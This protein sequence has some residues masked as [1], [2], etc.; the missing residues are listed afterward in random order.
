MASTSVLKLSV[1]DREYNASLKQAAQGMK[2]L[3]QTL[4]ESGRSFSQA[5]KSVVEYVQGIG[6]METRSKTARGEINEMTSAFIELSKIYNKMS[7]EAKQGD[8][9]K[10]LSQ[11]L[12]QLRK[13]TQES[14]AELDNI[15]SSIN[16]SNGLS[17]ALDAIAG[18]FGLSIDQIT[19]FGSAAGVATTVVKVAKDAFFNNEEQLDEWGRTVEAA[20]S[21]YKGFLNSLNTGDI[22]GFLNNISTITQAAREAYNALD[23]LATFNAFNKA[24]IAK[25]RAGLTG[26]IADYREGKGSKENVSAASQELIKQ[27]EARQKLQRDAYE[28]V[29]SKVAQERGVNAKDLLKVMTGSYGSFKELK[30]LQYTGRGKSVVGA[31]MYAR[32]VDVAVPANERERLA[33]AVKHLNDTEIDNFQSIAEAAEM[34]QV[35]I[36]NQRKMVARVLNG[37][38]SGGSGGG[39]GGRSTGRTSRGGGGTTNEVTY[40]AD[41]IAAQEKLVS[42]LTK[43]WREAGASVRDDYKAQLDDAK[44][45]LQEMTNPSA[46]I[47][48]VDPAQIGTSAPNVSGYNDLALA[49]DEIT[50]LK[51]EGGSIEEIYKKIS[52]SIG[53]GFTNAISPL[54]ALN[55]ELKRLQEGQALALTP[56]QWQIWQEAIDKTNKKISDFTGGGKEGEKSWKNAATAVQAVGSAMQ[57]I[58]DPA[59][60]V[61]GTIAQAIASIALGYAQATVQAGE[62]GGPWAWIAFAASGL[63]TMLSTI[64]AIHSATGYAQGGIV[65]GRGGGFVPGS[66]F[67]GDNVGNVMLDSGELILNRVQQNSLANVLTGNPMS[68]M[69]LSAVVSG[70]QILLVANR[71]TRRQGRGELVTFR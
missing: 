6:N 1:D 4:Q 34:T 5:G 35:E 13:R 54:Q 26:A 52:E 42:E 30:D 16:G 31:G 9:G 49:R 47:M 57:G 43:K 3:E 41:S 20:E 24:N 17:G 32:T 68:S 12:D 63:A 65:D 44:T 18:K 40:A 53:G 60:K 37:R 55:D 62:T 38:G 28:K 39:G 7:D 51:E 50:K 67:S 23:E 29:V 2:H 71:T 21:V 11:S 69:R 59:A 48:R 36:D 8:V 56:E 22:S 27:L 14:K 70:E 45:K 64:S 25:S 10:A 33:R 66:S 61:M 58:E 46:P 15:N 19:K